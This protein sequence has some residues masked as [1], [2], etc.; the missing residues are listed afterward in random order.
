M[1]LLYGYSNSWDAEDGGQLVIMI[2]MILLVNDGDDN[3]IKC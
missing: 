1:L 3:I 2:M